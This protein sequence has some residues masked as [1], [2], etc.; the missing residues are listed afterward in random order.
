MLVW[1]VACSIFFLGVGALKRNGLYRIAKL[2][3]LFPEAASCGKYLCLFSMPPECKNRKF[4]S[5]TKSIELVCIPF[6]R[7]NW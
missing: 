1:I 2:R 4:R 5:W 3:A 7:N 6:I